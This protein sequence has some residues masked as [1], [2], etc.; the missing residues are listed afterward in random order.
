[1]PR[2]YPAFI[3]VKD[4]TCVVIGGGDF[5]EEKVVKLLECDASVRVISTHVNESVS[6]MAEKGIIEWLRR[7]YQA[8]DLSDAFIAIAADNP[9]DVNLQI[10]EEATERNVPLNVVDVTHLCTFIAPSVAR[11]GE[12]TVL[13]PLVG[14]ALLWPGHLERKLNPIALVGC[15]NM[16]I[17]RPYSHGLVASLERGDGI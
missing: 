14:L 10:A 13:H 15:L 17:W 2:Y 6:E 12:V 7:T 4:R 1:M 16:R 5:G 9:E 11:R 3:D 8:G